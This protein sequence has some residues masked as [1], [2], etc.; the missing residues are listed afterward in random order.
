MA[1]N[2]SKLFAS[3]S[4]VDPLLE[5]LPAELE[6]RGHPPAVFAPP[7]SSVSTKEERSRL[8][9]SSDTAPKKTEADSA[10]IADTTCPVRAERGAQHALFVCGADPSSMEG[11]NAVLQRGWRV[12]S[13]SPATDPDG[14][15]ATLAVLYYQG[16]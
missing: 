6:W 11:L 12:T 3:D 1:F 9:I 4:D 13:L 10:T 14:R 7:P 5:E 16:A 8:G 15:N 2:I